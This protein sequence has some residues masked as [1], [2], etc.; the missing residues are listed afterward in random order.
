MTN[1]WEILRGDDGTIEDRTFSEDYIIVLSES[2]N[3]I[4][5]KFQSTV[6]LKIVPVISW[7]T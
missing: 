3:E 5:G 4:E 7:S 2:L 6:Q 1:S